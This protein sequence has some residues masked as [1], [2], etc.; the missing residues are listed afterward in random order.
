MP[1]LTGNNPL[2]FVVRALI[3]P[4]DER[5]IAATMGALDELQLSSNWEKEGMMSEDDSAKAAKAMLDNVENN[6]MVGL[7]FYSARRDIPPY[8]LVC[9]GTIY[10]RADYPHLYEVIDSSFVIDADHFSVP[11]LRDRA[12]LMSGQIG[13]TGGQSSITISTNNM[14]SHT[15][16]DLGHTHTDLGHTHTDGNAIP[17]LLAIGAGVPSPSAIPSIG[18]T[19]L[20]NAN[21]AQSNANIQAAG[22]G[23]SIDI[24]PKYLSL[25]AFIVAG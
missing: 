22:G 21:I 25:R 4:R 16:T 5:F 11:D 10:M 20:S 7:I 9:D 14:P 3:I 24:T 1:Y 13:S 2:G 19:G 6:D 23:Q 17:T 8:L 12:A 15:H 18:I